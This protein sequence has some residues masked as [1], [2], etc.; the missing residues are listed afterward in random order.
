[1]EAE[2]GEEKSSRSPIEDVV[3]E[4]ISHNDVGGGR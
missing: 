2:D 1:M 4:E 3:G